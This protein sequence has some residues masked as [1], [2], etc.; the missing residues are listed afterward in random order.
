MG[1]LNNKQTTSHTRKPGL[2]LE[3]ETLRETESLLIAVQ[4]N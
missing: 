1:A 2:G 3:K 4:N